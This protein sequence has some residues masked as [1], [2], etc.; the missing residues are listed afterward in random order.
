MCMYYYVLDCIGEFWCLI[1]SLVGM[2]SVRDHVCEWEKG[3]AHGQEPLLWWGEL[4]HHSPGG[5]MRL[6]G[7]MK[8]T[9]QY[10]FISF[11][12]SLVTSSAISCS[13]FIASDCWQPS[14][15]GCESQR[16]MVNF[17]FPVVSCSCTSVSVYLRVHQSPWAG[18]GTGMLTSS[19]SSLWPMVCVYVE[20]NYL[21]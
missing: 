8:K 10:T 1:L 15:S 6:Q 16:L 20:N 12:L 5:G 14:P 19:P 7:W 11:T 13:C 21:I 3:S 18:A 9:N 17:L 4:V 2:H